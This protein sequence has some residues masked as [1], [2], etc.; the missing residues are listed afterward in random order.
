LGE[1]TPAARVWTE[2]KLEQLKQ[3]RWPQVCRALNQLRLTGAAAATRDETVRHLRQHSAQL[4]YDEYRVADLLMGSGAIKGT[5]KHLVAARRNQA[6]MR[7]SAA[8]MDALLA[9][10]C[11]VLNEQLDPLL[12]PPKLKLVWH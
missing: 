11:T 12:P 10:H 8:G 2:A 6:G 9:L 3:G 1:G 4:A 5:C 7:W